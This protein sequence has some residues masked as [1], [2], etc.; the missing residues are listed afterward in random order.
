[1]KK[2][3]TLFQPDGPEIVTHCAKEINWPQWT[4][5]RVLE[6]VDTKGRV[7]TTNLP[8]LVEESND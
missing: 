4:Q 5:M 8:F 1:M 2:L 7:W 3:V 6:F